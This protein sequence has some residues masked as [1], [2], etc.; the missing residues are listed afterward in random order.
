MNYLS[1]VDS[2]VMGAIAVP[3][4]YSEEKKLSVSFVEV[5]DWIAASAHL[6]LVPVELVLELEGAANSIGMKV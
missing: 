3:M 4:V 1:V 6:V 5:Q 2:A